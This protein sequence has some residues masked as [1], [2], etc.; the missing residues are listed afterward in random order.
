MHATA[1][2]GRRAGELRRRASQ[3]SAARRTRRASP[4]PP[5][6]ADRRTPVRW[7]LHLAD[8]DRTPTADDEVELVPPTHASRRGSDSRGAGSGR[9]TRRSDSGRAAA[10]AT[11]SSAAFLELRIA[12][13]VERPPMDGTRPTA[14]A[15]ARVTRRDVADVG[16]EAV[17]GKTASKRCIA[18]HG[19]PWRRST[20]PRGGNS[21][22][23]V[24]HCP[25]AGA[26]CGP[27]R[28]RLRGKSAAGRREGRER[29]SKPAEVRARRPSRRSP[30]RDHADGNPRAQHVTARKSPPPARVDLLR[31]VEDA[32]GLT[33][34]SRSRS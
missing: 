34:W 25:G 15:M 28:N 9:R 2:S 19:R 17:A 23:P 27:S 32:R 13:C 6:P 18:G 24:D 7:R 3:A 5:T 22:C 8:D 29:L 11:G 33:R 21:W 30:R 12:P 20:R 4:A 31:V 16:G 10:R 1:S 14:A 26:R